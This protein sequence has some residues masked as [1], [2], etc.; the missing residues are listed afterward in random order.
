M[1]AHATL[2]LIYKVVGTIGCI[3]LFIYI[4]RFY[5]RRMPGKQVV[6]FIAVNLLVLALAYT[7][8]TSQ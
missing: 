6:L 3:G 2:L 4:W 5:L 1:M 7:I 8:I